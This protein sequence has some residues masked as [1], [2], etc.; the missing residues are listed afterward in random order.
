MEL[1][2]EYKAERRLKSIVEGLRFYQE[3]RD[4]FMSRTYWNLLK[5]F[6]VVGPLEN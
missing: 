3:E 5:G 1:D 2:I 6:L 4:L